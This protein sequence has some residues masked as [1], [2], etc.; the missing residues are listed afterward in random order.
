[1][2]AGRIEVLQGLAANAQVVTDG[3]AF[4]ENGE[5]VHVVAR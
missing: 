3:A 2:R 1:M 4:L 5:K